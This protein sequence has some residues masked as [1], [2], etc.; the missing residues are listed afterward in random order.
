MTEK[1]SIDNHL[2]T[3]YREYSYYVLESRAIPWLC[4]GLKN[5]QRRALWIAKDVAKTKTKVN[6]LAGLVMPLHP[7]GD[8]SISDAIGKLAQDFPGANNYPLFK[9][10]GA[11]GDRLSGVGN[12]IGASRYVS[13]K[14]SEFAKQV[15]LQDL[16][17]VET[18]PSYDGENIEPKHFLPLVPTVLLNGVQGIAV[19]FATE[20]LPYK[21]KDIVD[22]QIKCLRGEKM[23]E[24]MPYFHGFK[25]RVFK[26]EE[27][28]L[29]SEGIWNKFNAG[30][31][32]R[33]DITELPI[34]YNRES[35]IKVLE[36]LYEAGR[37]K[38]YVD[39]SKSG[40]SFTVLL[41][42]GT[43]WDDEQIRKTFR[44][45]SN[46]NQNLTIINVDGKLEKFNSVVDI[47]KQFTDWRFKFY[48]K[49]Y[50]KLVIDL[51]KKIDYDTM[52]LKFIKFVI[53]ERFLEVMQKTSKQQAGKE[54]EDRGFRFTDKLLATPIYSFTFEK[55]KELQ[56]TIEK[57]TKQLDEYRKIHGDTG[58]RSA[59]Y[60]DELKALGRLDNE[61]DKL[62]E[63]Q[64]S[65]KTD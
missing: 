17:L 41:H 3:R 55:I 7:H 45:E 38:D 63:R 35:Y 44:L 19:G 48:Q 5:V 42:R 40:F 59:I 64:G 60:T 25:G 43:D 58:K 14:V 6:T 39:N 62:L 1:I 54:L 16:E 24:P 12:G 13:V 61:R 18:Q 29:K 50:E 20:I 10:D 57:D 11:F 27:G 53:K 26:G 23:K 65:A 28:G 15:F 32:L 31:E 34:G 22:L 56:D 47:I 21:L 46:L 36:G 33:L 8:V 51:T 30:R 49:R 52:L 4:D 9:G 37:I 2:D